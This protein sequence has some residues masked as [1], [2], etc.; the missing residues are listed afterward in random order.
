MVA[1]FSA[2]EG[3]EPPAFTAETFRSHGCGPDPAFRAWVAAVGDTPDLVG[4]TV[5]TRGFDTQSGTPGLTIEDLYV[6]PAYRR[7]GHGRGLVL[8]VA[9]AALAQG[10]GWV[11]WHVRRDNPDALAFYRALGAIPEPVETM[12]FSGTALQWFAR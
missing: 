12:A 2:D 7:L 6:K 8:A 9:R 11:A 10:C 5:V 1:A 4:F 3:V